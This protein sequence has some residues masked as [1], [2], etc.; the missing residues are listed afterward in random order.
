M[1]RVLLLVPTSTYRA[2]DF[3]AAARALGIEL[4]VGADDAPVVGDGDRVV[5][6]PLTDVPKAMETIDQLDR[7]RGVDA[8]GAV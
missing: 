8:G 1:T 4:V 2:P 7:R 5:S 3:V 6:I